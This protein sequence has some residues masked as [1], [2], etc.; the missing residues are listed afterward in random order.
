[1]LEIIIKIIANNIMETFSL[2]ASILS[3]IIGIIAIIVA[4]VVAR[5]SS[6]DTEK[7]IAAMY[8]LLDIV[9]AAQS[10]IMAESLKK[11]NQQLDDVKNKIQDLK[12][13]KPDQDTPDM[14][15]PLGG[16]NPLRQNDR[17]HTLEKQR[18]DIIIQIKL[19]Q[20]YFDKAMK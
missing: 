1:M 6:R 13:G 4:L 19:L 3:P 2:W 14:Q 5:S 8:K 12:E 7:Q 17:I 15:I 11:Y 9:I 16:N 18:D 10:P 20:S